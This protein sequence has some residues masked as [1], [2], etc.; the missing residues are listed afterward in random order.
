MGVTPALLPYS[1]EYLV[2]VL[3]SVPVIL[4]GAALSDVMRAEGKMNLVMFAMLLSSITN[5]ILDPIAIFV[6]EWGVLGVALATVF[7][8]L[9]SLSLILYFYLAG[10]TEI[11]ITFRTI[12]LKLKTSFDIISLGMPV[13]INYFGVSL[14][15]SL[16]NFSLANAA[17]P[18][19]NYM[20]S[21]YGL[22]GARYDVFVL[23]VLRNDDYLSNFMQ[24]QLRCKSVF[25]SEGSV[26]ISLKTYPHCTVQY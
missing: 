7:S 16:V 25:K 23:P 17:L 10:K 5:I 3:S 20:I 19:S 4:L 2:P 15:I 22:L 1:L 8:Q 13:F 18:E 21:A 11:K 26:C 12:R 24:L 6:L 9:L 14:I